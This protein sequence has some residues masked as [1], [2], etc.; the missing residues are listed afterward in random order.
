MTA[1]PSF[2]PDGTKRSPG[3]GPRGQLSRR[4]LTGTIPMYAAVRV[5]L[6]GYLRSH[7]A[8]AHEPRH[9]LDFTNL[10]D[11]VAKAAVVFST[12][13][14]TSAPQVYASRLINGC[15]VS[16]DTVCLG[17]YI[18]NWMAR[19]RHTDPDRKYS[20]QFQCPFMHQ[21]VCKRNGARTYPGVRGSHTKP[22]SAQ[23]SWALEVTFSAV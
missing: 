1:V 14:P 22:W 10:F 19:Y 2:L 17:G 9:N 21:W 18:W 20:L 3:H 6:Y 4:T 7:S 5:Q 11:D 15:P 16:S 12:T 13:T 23:S 8:S